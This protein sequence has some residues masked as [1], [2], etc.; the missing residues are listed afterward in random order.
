MWVCEPIVT[1]PVEAASR[2]PAQ[3]AGAAPPRKRLAVVDE[4]GGRIE[5][6]GDPVLD[7]RRHGHV[8]EV[9][10]AV[11]ERDHH[12]TLGIGRRTVRFHRRITAAGV[13]GGRE[14]RHGLIEGNY[15]M[16]LTE[17]GELVPEGVDV[18]VDFATEPPP[19]RW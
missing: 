1:S 3:L 6:R 2:R 5:R 16:V 14:H 7:Q 10:G 15:A 19:T 12:G 13:G 9:V 8:A 4:V 11:V 18:E 17:M